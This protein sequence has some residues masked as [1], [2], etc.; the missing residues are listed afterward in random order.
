MNFSTKRVSWRKYLELVKLMRSQ[1]WIFRG[2]SYKE[3]IMSSLER[4]LEAYNIPLSEAPQ[5][6]RWMIRDFR[7]KYEGFDLE[8]VSED[9]FYCLSL[10][11]H[12]G[13]PTRLLDWTYSP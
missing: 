1:E 5:I 4:A 2:Q 13:C 3:P 6:E 7:R 8:I 11:Q 9:T 12:Y 10:M